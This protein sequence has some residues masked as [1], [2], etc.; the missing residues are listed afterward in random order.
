MGDVVS[1]E[2]TDVTNVKELTRRDY[3][4]T[5][6]FIAAMLIDALFFLNIIYLGSAGYINESSIWFAETVTKIFPY[7]LYGFFLSLIL[8]SIHERRKQT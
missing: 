7:L 3:A 4:G 2:K 5:I 1:E 8:E 6:F